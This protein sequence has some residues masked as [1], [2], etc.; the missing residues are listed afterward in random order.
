VLERARPILDRHDFRA[1]VFVP[2]SFPDSGNP[3]SWAGIDHWIGGPHASELGC[4]SWAQ[5]ADLERDG[6]EVGSHTHTHPHLTQIDDGALERELRVSRERI[7][8]RLGAPCESIAYP[9]GD[10]DERVVAAAE[11]AGYTYGATLTAWLSD[12]R[13][14]RW[15]RVG[16]YHTD[17]PWRFRAKLSPG[18]RRVAS[19]R[20][21]NPVIT[22]IRGR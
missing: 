6:W 22:R 20:A 4:L 17:A 9:Y 19:T 21:A 8:E 1:T 14:L 15:P 18:V 2:T 7:G 11:R 10:F 12:R 16:V 5:L 3:L 13:A